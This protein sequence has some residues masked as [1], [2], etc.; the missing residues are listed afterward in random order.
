MTDLQIS[1]YT[2]VVGALKRGAR[3]GPEFE[4][5]A[6]HN[7]ARQVAPEV[8]VVDPTTGDQLRVVIEEVK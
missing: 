6:L 3:I 1:V 8:L 5:R 2:T 4:I 7:E